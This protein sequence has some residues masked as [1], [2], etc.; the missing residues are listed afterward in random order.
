M[1]LFEAIRALKPGQAIEAMGRNGEWERLVRWPH[2]DKGMRLEAQ[3]LQIREEEAEK[4]TCRIIGLPAPKL[5]LPEAAKMI[6]ERIRTMDL[7]N[8]CAFE[9]L[10]CEGHSCTEGRILYALQA[11]AKMDIDWEAK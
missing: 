9:D 8:N 5:T 6:E 3:V 11:A 2:G 7:C 4:G 10:S 1:T